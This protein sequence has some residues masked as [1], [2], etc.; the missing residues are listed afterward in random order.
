[1]KKTIG[2]CSKCGREAH[3][4]ARRMCGTCLG[5]LYAEGNIR[6]CASCHELRPH[7]SRGLCRMCWKRHKKAGDLESF[8]KRPLQTAERRLTAVIGEPGECWHWRWRTNVS[9]YGT[10]MIKGVEHFAHRLAYERWNGPIPEGLVIDHVCHNADLSCNLDS[11]C[12]HRSCCNPAH[13]EAV[14]S[15]TNSLRG[16]TLAAA[17]AAKTHCKR[18]HEFTPENTYRPPSGGRFCR[19]CTSHKCRE[20]KRKKRAERR[21]VV[22]I[23]IELPLVELPTAA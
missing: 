5:R 7:S 9:G 10:L 3:L 1:M 2:A 20:W 11:Q 23:P 15:A 12:P 6:E 17:N 19:I 8:P 14:T 16:H 4:P 22:Y 21:G 18:G 13:L